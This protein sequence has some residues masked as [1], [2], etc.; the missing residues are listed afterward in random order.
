LTYLKT[1]NRKK[2]K[3][4]SE[5]KIVSIAY[6]NFKTSFYINQP[7]EPPEISSREKEEKQ[8]SKR[9]VDDANKRS[10]FSRKKRSKIT[11]LK[12]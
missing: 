1:N 3:N 12:K 6:K 7:Q 4:N 5:N 8:K 11:K 10:I 2:N 9:I